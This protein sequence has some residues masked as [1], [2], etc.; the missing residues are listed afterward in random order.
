MRHRA[1]FAHTL[2]DER[3]G[4]DA[5][6]AAAHADEGVREVDDL[7]LRRTATEH[8]LPSREHGC[9]QRIAGAGHGA[10]VRAGQVDGRADKL[11]RFG[12]DVAPL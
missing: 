7:R 9:G 4:P 2:D 12:H 11:P 10:A 5:L 1:E 6:H 8:A 3:R